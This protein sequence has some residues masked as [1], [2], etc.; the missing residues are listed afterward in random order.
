MNARSNTYNCRCRSRRKLALHFS[1]QAI[2]LTPKSGAA[3]HCHQFGTLC[4]QFKET[5]SFLSSCLRKSKASNAEISGAFKSHMVTF[6]AIYYSHTVLQLQLL[7]TGDRIKP[8]RNCNC[9][10]RS[11]SAFCHLAQGSK[12]RRRKGRCVQI[13]P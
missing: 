5:I 3:V 10:P 4:V 6:R 13:S 1:Q 11:L 2:G 12:K 9:N 7:T 8:H